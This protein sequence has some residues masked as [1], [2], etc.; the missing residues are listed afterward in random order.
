[1]IRHSTVGFF[2]CVTLPATVLASTYH[3]S[4]TG[5][6][7]AAGSATAPW[8]TVQHAADVVQAGDAVVIHAGTY[9]GFQVGTR[10][11][12]AAPIAFVAGGTVTIDGTMTADQD[13][14]HVEN[15][16]CISIAG[17]RVHGDRARR[18]QRA[19]ERSHLRA[20]QSRR[21]ERQVGR[22][23]RLLRE[24]R[25]RGQRGVALGHAARHLRVEQSS[26]T[27]SSA[28][29]RSGATRCAAST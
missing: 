24:L 2:A 12:Q 21:S 27:R 7:N 8:R 13:A 16:S 29:T 5:D 23:L 6:D 26:T 4:T 17:S 19:H 15:A 18:H 11:T 9:A 14:I 1:M 3:V 20:R 28:T 22:V 25:R 10:A